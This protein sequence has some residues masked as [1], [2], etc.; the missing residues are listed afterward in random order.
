MFKCWE[1]TDASYYL[2]LKY[3]E[4]RNF[5]GFSSL[6][7]EMRGVFLGGRG[8]EIFNIRGKERKSLGDY[9]KVGCMHVRFWWTLSHHTAF[10]PS[11]DMFHSH[12]IT[13]FNKAGPIERL[14]LG[15]EHLKRVILHHS[16][17]Q[18]LGKAVGPQ[19]EPLSL[20]ALVPTPSPVLSSPSFHLL[21]EPWSAKYLRFSPY[22][23]PLLLPDSST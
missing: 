18:R 2:L 3:I 21:P 23:Q 22:L 1:L 8:T 19:T 17:S 7:D 10:D 16:V 4:F 20:W 5:L 6:R 9:S 15:S 13:A 11:L 14:N 12:F